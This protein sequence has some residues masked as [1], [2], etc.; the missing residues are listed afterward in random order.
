MFFNM[1]WQNYNFFLDVLDLITKF[2]L[3]NEQIE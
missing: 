3:K 2:I 1:V